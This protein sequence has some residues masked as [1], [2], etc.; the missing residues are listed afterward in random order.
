MPS[1]GRGEVARAV[2]LERSSSSSP[3]LTTSTV[4]PAG[5]VSATI[6]RMRCGE[7]L[8]GGIGPPLVRLPRLAPLLLEAALVRRQQ[9]VVGAGRTRACRTRSRRSGARR[10]PRRRR[11]GSRLAGRASSSRRP[12]A[13]RPRTAGR[14][15]PSRS[16]VSRRIARQN[17]VT[18]RDVEHLASRSRARAP[19]NSSI[20]PQ[21]RVVGRD[22]GLVPD[23]VRDRAD[24]ADVGVVQRRAS[25]AGASPAGPACRRSAA[26]ARRRARAPAPGCRPARSRRCRGSAPGARAGSRAAS[27]RRYSAVPSREPL[28]TTITSWPG[29]SVQASTL[30]RPSARTAGCRG[31]RSRC[32]PQGTAR[33]ARA[34]AGT[35]RLERSPPPSRAAGGWDGARPA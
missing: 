31:S 7:P 30:S 4:A 13:A 17:I 18:R 11:A 25:G 9:L 2:A 29:Y 15:G 21:V 8:V 10:R 12:R 34:A 22:L 23:P 3:L 16:N 14:A 32:W 1:V 19:A 24:E 6:S 20:S 27:S 33:D 26:R 35:G 28:S 5:S